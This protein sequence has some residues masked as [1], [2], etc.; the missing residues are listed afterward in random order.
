MTE[1]AA[2]GD[3]AAVPYASGTWAIIALAGAL[4]L[5][6]GS[7]LID[8][9]RANTALIKLNK[10]QAAAAIV[11]HK[12]EAQLNALARG[13]QQLADSGNANAAAIVAVLQRNG[14]RINPG[15]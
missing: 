2:S 7:S 8:L 9:G 15:K 10:D 1:D 14:I 6:L 13:V 5:V 4:C 11:A 3:Y 12:G